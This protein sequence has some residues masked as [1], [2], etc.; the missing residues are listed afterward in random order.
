MSEEQDQ[1]TPQSEP[2]QPRPDEPQIAAP[3][4]GGYAPPRPAY[5][6][7]PQY[8]Y[9]GSPYAGAV[10]PP[11]KPRPGWFWPVIIL[12]I[13]LAVGLFFWAVGYAVMHSSDEN[14]GP[15]FASSRIA[16]ID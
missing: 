5:A 12:G 9:A 2:I 10:Y 4:P 15:A 11:R 3:P 8:A 13:L 14:S 7:A 6:Y 16:V 1:T